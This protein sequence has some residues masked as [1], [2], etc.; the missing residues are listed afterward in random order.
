MPGPPL[1]LADACRADQFLLVGRLRR[2]LNGYAVYRDTEGTSWATK[3][4][5]GRSFAFTWLGPGWVLDPI[6]QKRRAEDLATRREAM[7]TATQER[8]Q[9]ELEAVL[10]KIRLGPTAERLL[11]LIHQQVLRQRSSVLHLPDFAIADTLWGSQ[12]KP[13]HWRV[14]VL[15]I[16][17]GLT[18][19]HVCNEPLN[20]TATP[21]QQTVL[22]NHVV[23][24]RGKE[25]DV[26]RDGCAGQGIGNHHHFLVNVGQGFLGMLEDFAQP[27]NDGVVRSYA[28][29]IGGRKLSSTLRRTGKSGQL[30]T[31][32]LPAKLGDRKV[33]EKLTLRQH[34][35]LQAIVRETTRNT[36]EDRR[37]VSEAEVIHGNSI[38]TFDGKGT[39]TC[40]DLDQDKDYV[41]F[42][43]NKVLKGRGYLVTSPSGWLAKAGYSLDQLGQFFKDIDILYPKL[44]IIPAGIVKGG[45]GCLDLDQLSRLAHSQQKTKAFKRIHLRFYTEANYL[46]RWNRVFKWSEEM[47]VNTVMTDPTLT[48]QS[49]LKEKGLSQRQLA[50]GMGVDTSLLNKVLRGKKPWPTGWLE[51]AE[52]WLSSVDDIDLY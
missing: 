32:Y 23:D 35:L 34:R 28:F 6:A 37:S 13:T 42:N 30:V 15:K 7:S 52:Q 36:K 16:L 25:N 14:E 41:G 50:K 26:C 44:K 38:L 47:S 40:D 27:E 49:T 8:H 33:C 9:Q 24:L 10:D 5:S 4:V 11:W 3:T 45:T 43:G 51:R 17:R 48:V 20:Q 29:P 1:I 18:W 19:L 31:I 46:A 21:G 22:L 12:T 39:F 2:L